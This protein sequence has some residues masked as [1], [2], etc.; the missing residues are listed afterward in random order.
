MK[1]ILLAGGYG[2][3][4]RPITNKTPKCLVEI[5][6]KPLLLH[7]IELL[8]NA[9]VDS[10]LINTHH[11][12]DQVESFVSKSKYA[13]IIT[14]SYEKELLGTAGTVKNNL[15]FIDDDSIILAHA[16]NYTTCDL[17]EFIYAHLT[18]P[19]NT[20]MTM[21]LYN[22]ERPKESGIVE[23]DENKIVVSFVEKS[24]SPSSNLANAA[25]YIID[26][27]VVESIN[28][29][30]LSDFSTE[31]IPMF[32][33]QI[34]TWYNDCFHIDIGTPSALDLANKKA[35]EKNKII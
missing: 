24:E 20:C 7:W 12:A 25:V 1:A 18:K 34:N 11:L 3:R 27:K 5:N 31:V 16:D 29:Y 4:L 23:I 35:I 17:S 28:K 30:H 19:Q 6:N 26:T 13:D 14:L 21:M 32:M 2:T 9:G 22:S 8:V 15:N 33:G 10:I